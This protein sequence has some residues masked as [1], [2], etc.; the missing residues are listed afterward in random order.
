MA[1]KLKSF[2]QPE[3]LKTI[4]PGNLIPLLEPF[5]LFLEAKGLSFPEGDGEID[6]ATLGSILAQPDEEMPGDMVEMLYLIDFF[7]SDHRFDELLEIA[8]AKQIEVDG[9]ITA[10][11]LAAIIWLKHPE[12][13]QRKQHEEFFQKRKTFESFLAADSGT[14]IAVDDLATDLSKL[15]A[16]LDIYFAAKKRG[17]GCRVMRADSA[18]EVRF[19]VEHG[20]Q[21]TRKQSRVGPR[22]TATFYRPEKTDLVI[23]DLIHNELRI[24]ASTF[25]DVKEYRVQFGRHVFG[26]DDT[27]VFAEKYTLEP[28]KRDGRAALNC[29]DIAGLESVNLREVEYLWPGAFDHIEIHRAEGLFH[30]LTM[31]RR[32]IET[33]PLIRKAVFKFRLDGEKKPR[34]VTI[35]AGN[36]S[37]YNR[38]EEA[39]VIEDWLRARGYVLT[40]EVQNAKAE[41]AL[42]GN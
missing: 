32:E 14:V 12:T 26:G 6:V 40:A 31:I 38:G 7:G 25:T 39:S 34:S 22:S 11:D 30:A 35:K 13:L 36:K 19:L 3:L 15:E 37:G 18:G 8:A 23:Y 33:E 4:H 29:R 42:A 2:S 28:L 20:Q 41:S 5:R 1:L 21:C 16:A 9:E 10:L 24:N 17:I 27:F